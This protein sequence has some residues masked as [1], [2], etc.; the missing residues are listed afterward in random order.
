MLSGRL[1]AGAVPDDIRNGDHSEEGSYLG[2]QTTHD[3][4]ETIVRTL[5]A[6]RILRTSLC[7]RAC[8]VEKDISFFAHRQATTFAR[9]P[10]ESYGVG[11][12]YCAV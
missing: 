5:L 12:S 8:V 1:Q 2:N 4:A 7:H 10:F 6:L 11:A 3:Y 9:P